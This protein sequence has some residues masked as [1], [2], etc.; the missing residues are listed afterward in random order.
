VDNL[1]GLVD[2]LPAL[3]ELYRLEEFKVLEEFLRSLRND[4]Y[5][6]L[7]AVKVTTEAVPQIAALTAQ[8]NLI[9]SLYELPKLVEAAK[10]RMEEFK[11]LQAQR[12]TSQED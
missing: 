8:L 12:I 10:I 9:A 4:F 3:K 6:Q 1:E 7:L 11:K 5:S 2:K